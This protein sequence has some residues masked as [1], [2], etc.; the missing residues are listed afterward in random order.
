MTIQTANPFVFAIS[1][2]V[3]AI[4]LLGEGWRAVWLATVTIH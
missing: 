1:I 4:V 3:I 2:I